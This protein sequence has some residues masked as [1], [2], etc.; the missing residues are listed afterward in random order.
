MLAGAA[1]VL[2]LYTTGADYSSALT[3]TIWGFGAAIIFGMNSPL[4]GFAGGLI[5]GMV[6]ALCAGY[7][8]G[9]WATAVPLIFI[10]VILSMGRMNQIAA[11]GGRV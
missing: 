7:L 4:R 1:G 10:F 8:P 2:I 9:T 5:I 3:L 6:Q 11:T